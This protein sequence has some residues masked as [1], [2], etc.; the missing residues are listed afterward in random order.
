M[1]RFI[2]TALLGLAGI[3][4]ASAADQR[5]VRRIEEKYSSIRPAAADL[6]LYELNWAPTFQVAKEQAA[7]E[8]RP[9]FL[10]VVTNSFGDVCSGHC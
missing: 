3:A 8:Q 10:I 7:R 4:L 1:K 5:D 9:I 6:T 2:A